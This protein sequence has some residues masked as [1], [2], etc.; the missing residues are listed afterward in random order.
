MKVQNK[1]M[2]R[3]K[4]IKQLKSDI[5]GKYQSKKLRIFKKIKQKNA[6]LYKP[7]AGFNKAIS[8][9][10]KLA[11]K[12]F[13]A[14]LQYHGQIKKQILKQKVKKKA[15]GFSYSHGVAP[16]FYECHLPMVLYRMNV[17]NTIFQANEVI[18]C[19]YV[20]VNGQIVTETDLFLVPG[21][22]IC[23]RRANVLY[24]IKNMRSMLRQRSLVANTPEYFLYNY[25]TLSAVLWR[26]PH[27]GEAPYAYSF[28]AITAPGIVLNYY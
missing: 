26:F 16:Y 15:P 13:Y 2:P 22:R 25:K 10:K 21:D 24:F 18:R 4:V 23:I 19:G 3:F 1:S 12:Q 7:S 9:D 17:V 20:E 6:A 5:W 27:F 8:M 28:G 11:I 14:F